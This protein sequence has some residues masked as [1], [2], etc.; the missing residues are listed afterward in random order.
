MTTKLR[1][2]TR[3]DGFSLSALLLRLCGQPPSMRKRERKEKHLLVLLTKKEKKRRVV[4]EEIKTERFVEAIGLREKKRATTSEPI[5]L[6]TIIYF[7]P[8]FDYTQR[9]IYSELY[10]TAWFCC[11]SRQPVQNFS[12]APA[13]YRAYAGP[14]ERK[15]PK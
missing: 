6:P 7:R 9:Q 13:S 4:L 12:L 14:D 1:P 10:S 8:R 3:Q 2:R 15:N 11:S 5:E